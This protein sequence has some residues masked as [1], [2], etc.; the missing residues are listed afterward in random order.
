MYVLT[1]QNLSFCFYL[2]N[3]LRCGKYRRQRHSLTH[4]LSAKNY[5]SLNLTHSAQNP[6]ERLK[7]TR[8]TLE[9]V[10]L[11]FSPFNMATPAR[12]EI[13]L[14]SPTTSQFSPTSDAVASVILSHGESK[15]TPKASTPSKDEDL[16]GLFSSPSELILSQDS[17]NEIQSPYTNLDD[18]V[19]VTESQ[20]RETLE[21]DSDDDF[22]CEIE[23]K[24]VTISEVIS[25]PVD[26]AVDYPASPVDSPSDYL[27]PSPS[28]AAPVVTNDE[29]AA[30][31]PT[32]APS[33]KSPCM[34]A[35][36]TA[37]RVT[38]SVASGSLKGFS[39]IS[40]AD[41]KEQE[42]ETHPE[43][44]L[45]T[46]TMANPE[47]S[48]EP[49]HEPVAA[50]SP[51]PTPKSVFSQSFA[52]VSMAQERDEE[53]EDEAPTPTPKKVRSVDTTYRLAT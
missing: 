34:K 48:P 17:V 22:E 14:F 42:E 13:P 30:P 28:E 20:I 19:E 25:T 23:F 41:Q 7:K 18:T 5:S 53:D 37:R 33:A 26:D 45:E 8:A 46:E 15:H 12:K 40:H 10:T 44:M 6:L 35:A 9:T 16:L 38:R 32:P 39:R 49:E 2:L 21:A 43:A 29:A 4:T 50:P 47:P 1:I 27:S 52:R 24:T 3:L 11:L 31:T 36:V 51:K